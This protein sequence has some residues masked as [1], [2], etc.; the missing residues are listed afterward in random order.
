MLSALVGV[1]LRQLIV[2][3]VCL[4]LDIRDGD[5]HWVVL[6]ACNNSASCMWFTA[7]LAVGLSTFLMLATGTVMSTTVPVRLSAH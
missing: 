2:D 6:Q 3:L 4:S 1:A 7:A 5:Y